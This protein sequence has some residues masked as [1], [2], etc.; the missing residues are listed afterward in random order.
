MFEGK[1]GKRKYL[2]IEKRKSEEEARYLA[3]TYWHCK[4]SDLIVGGAKK[5][6]ML[7][8]EEGELRPVFY[9][10]LPFDEGNY[11]CLWRGKKT[12]KVEIPAVRKGV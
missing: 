4:D 12:D 10:E 8:R 6:G 1:I 9:L 2:V 3:R 11:W 5:K 7:V